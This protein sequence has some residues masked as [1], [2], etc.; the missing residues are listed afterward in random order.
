M[1]IISASSALAIILLV[2]FIQ[3]HN[4]PVSANTTTPQIEDQISPARVSEDI[5]PTLGGEDES[6][7]SSMILNANNTIA[8]IVEAVASNLTANIK[9]SVKEVK[10]PMDIGTIL[11]NIG[12]EIFKPLEE[13]VDVSQDTSRWVQSV[14]R[15]EKR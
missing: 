15:K 7:T 1:K 9:P 6:A 10:I 8:K 13:D 11:D 3:C 4:N 12:Q 5:T 14:P 2:S